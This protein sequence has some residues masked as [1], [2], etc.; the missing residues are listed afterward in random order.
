MT[1]KPLNSEPKGERK[2]PEK[3][4]S[5]KELKSKC[6]DIRKLLNEENHSTVLTRY[7]IGVIVLEVE[8]NRER[9]YGTG[10]VKHIARKVGIKAKTLY[11]YAEV[12][13]QWDEAALKKLL[14]RPNKHGILLTWSHLVELTPVKEVERRE[15]L[16]TVALDKGLSVRELRGHIKG[17][18][19]GA[20]E[21]DTP[22]APSGPSSLPTGGVGAS[23]TP[24]APSEQASL[25]TVAEAQE[26]RRAEPVRAAARTSGPLT[27]AKAPVTTP[28]SF[29]PA[30]ENGLREMPT[31]AR[32]WQEKMKHWETDVIEPILAAG[33]GKLNAQLRTQ[34]AEALK[35]F[36][37][38][39]TTFEAFLRRLGECLEG[40]ETP[41]V[42]AAPA[43]KKRRTKKK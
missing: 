15:K 7:K 3:D 6:Q 40:P 1:K 29:S 19:E 30:V 10:A 31:L 34:L 23:D 27:D 16:I 33:P 26:A 43:P 35:A 11:G 37:V 21:S 8:E 2:S 5:R 22:S 36:G 12:A 39:P 38:L 20:V 24:S 13:Q 14:E 28:S 25:P 9:H 18:S 32:R 41:P 17:G 42:R 4:V